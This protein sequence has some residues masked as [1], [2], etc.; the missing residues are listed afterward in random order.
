MYFLGHISAKKNPEKTWPKNYLGQD[1]DPHVFESRIRIRIGIRAII[2]SA[3]RLHRLFDMK[4]ACGTAVE[5]F[6]E[7]WKTNMLQNCF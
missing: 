6:F 2:G 3:A 4:A 5:F 1:P 7:D